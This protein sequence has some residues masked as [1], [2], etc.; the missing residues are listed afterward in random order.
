MAQYGFTLSNGK[1]S[2]VT[3]N[4]EEEARQKKDAYEVKLG[5]APKPETTE[6]PSFGD[7]VH[8]AL[9]KTGLSI[10]SV[11][12]EEIGGPKESVLKKALAS[13]NQTLKDAGGWGTA[14]DI[15]AQTLAAVPAALAT[16]YA[17]PAAG[18]AVLGLKALSQ[19]PKAA[20][21]LSALTSAGVATAGAA[22]EG[23][24]LAEPDDKEDAAAISGLIQVAIESVPI[25]GKGLGKTMTG[26]AGGS[27]V[28]TNKIKAAAVR[29]FE[30]NRGLEKTEMAKRLEELVE[31]LDLPLANSAKS[32]LVRK[33]A[34]ISEYLP[35]TGGR[36]KY[37]AAEKSIRNTLIDKAE[38]SAGAPKIPAPS[39]DPKSIPTRIKEAVF[40]EHEEYGRFTQE[41]VRGI[42]DVASK[43]YNRILNLRSFDP[44]ETFNNVLLGIKKNA[45]PYV[46]NLF[47]PMVK[48]LREAINPDTGMIDGKTIGT[49]KQE[50]RG[51]VADDEPPYRHQIVRDIIKQID[52]D[53]TKQMPVDDAARYVELNKLHPDRKMVEENVA[54]VPLGDFDPQ[55]ARQTL[56]SASG[57]RSLSRGEGLNQ[58][59]I[60]LSAD[61]M[62]RKPAGGS[63]PWALAAIIGTFASELAPIMAVGIGLSRTKIVSAIRKGEVPEG[64]KDPANFHRLRKMAENLTDSELA[65]LIDAAR[66][67]TVTSSGVIGTQISEKE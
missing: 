2:V 15:G 7:T 43:D 10:A 27:E 46:R 55:K 65:K 60:D 50:L 29:F 48:K 31:G 67:A 42:Q 64:L 53:L 38:G 23:A 14:A 21:A 26:L 9:S 24:L 57:N 18:T 22:G 66:A 40:G 51:M 54:G 49:L 6:V 5:I 37:F 33:M 45:D 61:I 4:S 35:F 44:R 39:P 11:I 41:R 59:L 58:E 52:D 8:S 47:N 34:E 19:F 63:S 12:P 17:A 32:A 3:A 36:E 16:A 25:V 56:Q 62:S 20:K 1:K 28:V 13:Q 30:N